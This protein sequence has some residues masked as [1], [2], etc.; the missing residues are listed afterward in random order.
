M[1]LPISAVEVYSRLQNGDA[2]NLLDV[3]EVIEFSTYNIGGQNIPLSKLP[4]SI[5]QLDYNKTDEIVVICKIGMR[6]ETACKL[7]QEKGYQNVR[8]LAGGLIAL[9]KIKQ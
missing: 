3:R 9:Q 7:L 6:S 4:S 5:D 1:S 8:N 2:I